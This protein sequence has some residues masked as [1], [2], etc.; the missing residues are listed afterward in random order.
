MRFSSLIALS[1]LG[2]TACATDQ[3]TDELPFEGEATDDGKADHA[4]VAFTELDANIGNTRLQQG[5][6]VILTSKAAWKRVMGTTAPAS[7]DFSKE[8]V[9]FFGTGVKNTGGFGAEITGIRYSASLGS[10]ILSTHAT[11]PGNDCIVTQAFTTPHHVVKFNIPSPRPIYALAD[12]KSE[13]KRCS[14]TNEE[15]KQELAASLQEWNRAKAVNGNS[16]TY[17]RMFQSFTGFSG[18][19][20]LVVKNG[21]VTERHYKAQHLSGGEATIWDEIG[22][23]VG[24]H[25]DEGFPAVLVDALYEQCR[26]DVLTQNETTNWMNFQVD[27]N[28]FLQACTYTPM[29]CQDDCSRG[30]TIS[31]IEF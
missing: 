9:A 10:L 16:Y 1:L 11:S 4:T 8:W 24:S 5:G 23:Q 19:T 2:V 25:T 12:A 26:T 29:A 13:V 7:V 18:R 3:N 14:P 21:V 20:T 30:P 6:T 28:G 27:S 22:A 17:T 15:R 31:S